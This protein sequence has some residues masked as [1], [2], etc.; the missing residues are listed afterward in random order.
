MTSRM[1]SVFFH[2]TYSGFWT[3]RS[4]IVHSRKHMIC[5]QPICA[6]HVGSK[7]ALQSSNSKYNQK[8]NVTRIWVSYKNLAFQKA[9]PC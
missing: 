6:K 2:V 1:Y 4:Q 8:Y 7:P 5:V 9:V 3:V